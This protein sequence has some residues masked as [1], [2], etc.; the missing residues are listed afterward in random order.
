MAEAM[1]VDRVINVRTVRGSLVAAKGPDRLFA[2]RAKG[3]DPDEGDPPADADSE[4]PTLEGE[5]SVALLFLAD[6]LATI[7][8]QIALLLIDNGEEKILVQTW[9]EAMLSRTKARGGFN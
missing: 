9:R 2:M 4:D 6:E 5:V 1:E 8:A 3:W 7:C